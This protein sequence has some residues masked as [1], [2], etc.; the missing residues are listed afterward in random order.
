MRIGFTLLAFAI[1][2]SI[3]SATAQEQQGEDQKARVQRVRQIMQQRRQTK[4]GEGQSG[5]AAAQATVGKQESATDSDEVNPP[6]HAKI[7][8]TA[9]DVAYGSA[10]T[11]KARR[12]CAT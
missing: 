9:S 7:P 10:E 8:A 6:G 1:A 12:V 2:S 11:T 4:Q 3:T 5:N